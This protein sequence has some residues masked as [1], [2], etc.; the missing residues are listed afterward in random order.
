[1]GSRVSVA[2]VMDGFTKQFVVVEATQAME[3]A[4]FSSLPSIS[5]V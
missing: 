1:M 3:I 4:V 5:H 2:V